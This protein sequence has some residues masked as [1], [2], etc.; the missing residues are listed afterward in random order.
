VIAIIFLVTNGK[1]DR[2]N[3]K[4]ETLEDKRKKAR[5]EL[6]ELRSQLSKK[7]NEEYLIERKIKRVLR[8]IRTG[9]VSLW[10]TTNTLCYFL[11]DGINIDTLLMYNEILII[12]LVAIIYIIAGSITDLKEINDYLRTNLETRVYKNRLLSKKTEIENV[13]NEIAIKEKEI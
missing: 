2:F 3:T 9:V 12:F 10:F 13:K 5:K 1:K 11:I 8:W 7:E 6:D 4:E